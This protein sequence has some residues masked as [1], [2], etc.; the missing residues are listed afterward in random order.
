MPLHLVTPIDRA[1]DARAEC[2][3]LDLPAI[4]AGARMPPTFATSCFA[5]APSSPRA[6]SWRSGSRCSFSF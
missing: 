6:T 3:S 4:E 2:D 5:A 1:Q